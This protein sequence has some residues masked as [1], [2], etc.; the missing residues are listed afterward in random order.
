MMA[1]YCQSDLVKVVDLSGPGTSFLRVYCILYIHTHIC[2]YLIHVHT[3]ML[4]HSHAR[5]LTHMVVCILECM[6]MYIVGGYIYS[7]IKV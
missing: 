5:T 6:T 2:I 4:T 7:Y 1:V 3:H